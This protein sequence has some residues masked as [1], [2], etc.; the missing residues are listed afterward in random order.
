MI[1]LSVMPAGVCSSWCSRHDA[2]Q[3][4]DADQAG[5]LAVLDQLRRER[6]A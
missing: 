5:E 3:P 2:L 1:R 6:V 4:A